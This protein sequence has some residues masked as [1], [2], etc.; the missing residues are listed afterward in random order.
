[1]ASTF[2]LVKNWAASDASL[3]ALKPPPQGALLLVPKASEPY[4]LFNPNGKANAARIVYGDPTLTLE[5][6]LPSA[7]ERGPYVWWDLDTD[8]GRVTELGRTGDGAPRRVEEHSLQTV[9]VIPNTTARNVRF[10]VQPNGVSAISVRSKNAYRGVSLY[11]DDVPLESAYNHPG[12][13]TAY[14]PDAL[15]QE[16]GAHLIT[17]RASTG[18]S[19]N[20]VRFNVTSD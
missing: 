12:L 13:V 11:W 8:S 1:M 6:R 2:G 3:A 20:A 16:A 18:V 4:N 17:L 7:T 5:Y 15:L 10:N 9:E 19:S 14:V